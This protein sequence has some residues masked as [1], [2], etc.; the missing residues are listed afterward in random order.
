L[1]GVQSAQSS[2]HFSDRAG[3]GTINKEER[4]LSSN[5]GPEEDFW[6]ASKV[7][8]SKKTHATFVV[9]SVNDI[10]GNGLFPRRSTTWRLMA[11]CFSR[12]TLDHGNG[13]PGDGMGLGL[14]DCNE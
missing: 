2:P 5:F 11:F 1:P 10:F 12:E 4:I 13:I 8:Q 9:L 6:Y 14:I 3:L 7:A